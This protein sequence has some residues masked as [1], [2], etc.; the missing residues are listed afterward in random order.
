MKVIGK[1]SKDAKLK[2][3]RKSNDNTPIIA[4]MQ[5]L[6]SD[7]RNQMSNPMYSFIV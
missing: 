6:T 1:L 2:L 5:P 4:D 3:G 7:M